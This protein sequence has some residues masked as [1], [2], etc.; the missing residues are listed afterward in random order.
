M[1]NNSDVEITVAF[2]KDDV[3][4]SISHDD[5]NESVVN[6]CETIDFEHIFARLSKCTT[7]IDIHNMFSGIKYVP[8]NINPTPDG[9]FVN[10][11]IDDICLHITLKDNVKYTFC[12]D[13]VTI[14][15]GECS[16]EEFRVMFNDLLYK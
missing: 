10:W 13:D 5:S 14:N 4:L 1:L 8:I 9:V 16:F 2:V 11:W 3:W 15:E 7:N 6:I 12:P